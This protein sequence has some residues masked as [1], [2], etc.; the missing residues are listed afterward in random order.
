MK[1]ASIVLV[2][3]LV[4][5][6]S[7]AAVAYFA[8]GRTT[9]AQPAEARPDEDLARE[10]ASLKSGQAELARTLAD[11]K[12]SFEMRATQDS[13]T[14]R[15]SLE[16][17]IERYLAKQSRL[18]SPSDDLSGASSGAA[19]AAP[20]DAKAAFA[21]LT[22]DDLTR[23]EKEALWVEL[24]KAGKLDEVIAEYEAL[25]ASDP[26]NPE[27]QVA[28]GQA[29][30]QKIFEVGSGPEAGVWATKADKAFDSALAL[31]DANWEARFSK[32]T[33]LSFWPPIFGKQAEAIR[34]FEILAA[35]QSHMTKDPQFVQTH[36]WLG[37]LYQQSGQM[38]KAVAAWQQGLLLFP[39]NAELKAKLEGGK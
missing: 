9:A 27:A 21:K 13:R 29:Y 14:S 22:G 19:E 23:A 32:A 3:A 33:S 1:P 2:S 34:H 31:D 36:L 35:Q 20:F 30:L 11:L 17:A 4:A 39:D 24:R 25:A 8:S 12:H 10:V 16:D 38:E 28:L 26:K 6:G 5:A 18:A 15:E 7:G 37:N